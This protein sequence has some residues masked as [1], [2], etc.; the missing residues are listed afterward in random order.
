MCLYDLIH[1]PL[2]S[3]KGISIVAE[4]PY[5]KLMLNSSR[6]AVHRQYFG[7][8]TNTGRI[9]Y[10]IG[11]GSNTIGSGSL[12]CVT[13]PFNYYIYRIASYLHKT[14]YYRSTEFLLNESDLSEQFNHCTVLLYYAHT[15][16][17]K[18]NN[19]VAYRLHV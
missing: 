15:E 6:P 18:I 1:E 2:N 19:W 17:K 11:S 13:R 7:R 12:T 3:L 4:K 14:L 16:L 8:D 5:G 10:G 9:T